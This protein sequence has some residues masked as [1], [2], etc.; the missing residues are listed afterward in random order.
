[1]TRDS[2]SMQTKPTPMMEQYLAIKARYPDAL[3]F[4]RMGDFYEMFFE[5]AEK[6]S[7]ILEITLTSRNKNQATPIPMCGVPYRAVQG[8]IARIIERGMKVAICD[9]VEDPALAKGLVRREVVRVITPG[10]IVENEFLE[11]KANNFLLAVSRDK[12]MIGLAYLDIST[13]TFRVTEADEAD[14]IRD[15]IARIS[16]REILFAESLREDPFPE[17]MIPSESRRSVSFLEDRCFGPVF[18][19][20][21]LTEQFGTLS[22]EGFGCEHLAA[23]IGAAGAV[24]H[25][26]LETQKQKIAHLKGIETYLL[27]DYMAIDDQSRRNLELLG[28]LR[29]GKRRGSLIGVLDQTVTAMGGRLLMNWIR[30]PLLNPTEIEA[31][32][33]A[34][35]EALRHRAVSEKIRHALEEVSDL[36]RLGGRIS[37]GLA[38]PRDMVALKRSLMKMPEILES[39]GGLRAPLLTWKGETAP[40]AAIA[41]LI[42]KA[43]REDAPMALNEGGIIKS[44]FNPDLD[45]LIKLSKDGKGWLVRLEARE[46]EQTGIASL[47]VRYNKVFGYY[48]E[49]PKTHAQ[50][51]PGHYIRKQ[52]LVNA[53][54]YITEELK[55]F[56]STVLNAEE[57]RAKLEYEIFGDVR[58]RINEERAYIQHAAE[59]VARLDCLLGLAH[60]AAR[61]DYHRPEIN[62]DGILS[63]EDGRHPVIEKMIT[64]ERFVPNSI[65]M[66]NQENQIL[67]ITGPNMAGKSTVLRQ[68]ALLTIMAQIGAFVPASC[69][70]IPVTDRIYT[71]VGALDNLSQGQST[72]MVE[73]QETANILNNATPASLVIL[74][75]IGRG[76]S[77][78]DGLSIAWAVAEYLHDLKGQGVKTLFATH[79][80]ELTDL[81]QT[82][83]KVKN[84]AIA[85]KEV[86]DRIIF[87]R[88]LVEGG[89]NR[90]YG[91]QVARLAGI[92][93]EVIE[94]AATI[95]GRIE[96]EGHILNKREGAIGSTSPP[97]AKPIQL[98]LFSAREQV[99]VEALR[100]ID[101]TRMTPLEAMIFLSEL[102][103][104]TRFC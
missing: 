18:G 40:L 75:E 52:T 27:S 87:L 16:P 64:G 10:M 19:R 41:D 5:D 98:G 51:V 8:Y 28:N 30:Y 21:L 69:A 39:A 81:E 6:A 84:Y 88:K 104:K 44:G 31:R 3:L 67:I 66:D 32:L 55:T 60:V 86:N 33:D 74:D 73:M 48:L 24:L 59:F 103:K 68:V 83:P 77:T 17:M 91:I 96:T 53:E 100:S 101:L 99:L 57:R 34:V 78:F 102:Q 26:V 71:R 62:N 54:R 80:H 70:N 93:A 43:I 58:T 29:S 25:Y 38:S 9:Q 76:T 90:S 22:L 15:E 85:V 63:I 56:E 72:F 35:E 89:T 49:V 13:G 79:Y 14:A 4:Y 94:R 50:K 23:G 7:K 12:R 20:R 36:D 97:D 92:P 42:E 95:L 11:A 37:M 45:E 1:M 65:R 61:S 46:K 2:E 47:K 82:K